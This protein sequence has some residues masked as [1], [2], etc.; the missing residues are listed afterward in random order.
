MRNI[1]GEIFRTWTGGEFRYP[2]FCE[3]FASFQEESPRLWSLPF[4][5]TE[6]S[7]LSACASL[8]GLWAGNL[9]DDK[10]IRERLFSAEGGEE[11]REHDSLRAASG[12][13]QTWRF[14]RCFTS[15]TITNVA[16]RSR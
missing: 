4:E 6:R 1:R 9:R 14:L 5:D 12:E 15:I 7:E 10:A 11:G 8:S 13:K 3:Y 2:R 16:S